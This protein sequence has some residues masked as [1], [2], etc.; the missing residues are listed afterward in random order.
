MTDQSVYSENP[1]APAKKSGGEHTWRYL[2]EDFDTNTA[3]LH[4]NP[5][6]SDRMR[7]THKDKMF[8]RASKSPLRRICLRNGNREVNF[9]MNTSLCRGYH[10]FHRTA[11]IVLTESTR[12]CSLPF[13][14]S[15]NACQYKKTKR[16]SLYSSSFVKGCDTR[17]KNPNNL[18]ATVPRI[19][20]W[21]PERHRV[22][23]NGNFS[24]WMQSA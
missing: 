12:A 22:K 9:V 5:S 2:L 19:F 4:V 24:W 14:A 21:V 10:I 15:A 3:Y 7:Q 23:R 11:R 13:W 17:A 1:I 8:S 16:E 18:P 6:F 20:A